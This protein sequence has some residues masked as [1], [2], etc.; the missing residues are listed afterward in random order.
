M[1]WPELT[2]VRARLGMARQLDRLSETDVAIDQLRSV[3][4][5][6]PAA[7]VGALADAHLQLG[8]ALDRL[9][10]HDDARAAYDAAVARTPAGDPL[11]TA[12]RA[13]A[14]QRRTPDRTAAQAY[15]LSLEG[16]RALERGD[17][18]AAG[19]ALDRSLALG[20][21]ISSPATARRGCCSR[22][23]TS[24]PPSTRSRPSIAATDTPLARLRGRVPRRGAGARAA[25]IDVARAIELYELT[26]AAFG[27]DPRAKSAAQRALARLAKPA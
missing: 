21:A 4:A 8:D 13:R 25:G 7:P 20:P 16:W 15:R 23:A 27:V 26:V 19:Q 17:I 9:G 10:A 14:A 6:A 11:K 3:V 24:A 2:E 5:A 1:A 18:S 22:S 12:A